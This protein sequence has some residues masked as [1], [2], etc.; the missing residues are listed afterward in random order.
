MKEVVVNYE[1]EISCEDDKLELC[2]HKI[3]FN[4]LLIQGDS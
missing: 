1:K 4:Q 3:S 2:V